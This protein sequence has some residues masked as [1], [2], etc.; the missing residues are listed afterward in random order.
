[1]ARAGWSGEAAQRI[2]GWLWNGAFVAGAAT[3]GSAAGL[4][5]LS[6]M[7]AR[8]LHARPNPAPSYAEAL[9][10]LDALAAGDDERIS[11]VCCN[12]RRP[13]SRT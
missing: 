1:M 8:G 3:V 5:W 13:S 11:P 12:T 10:R 6:R 2:G 7:K 9:T 4:N